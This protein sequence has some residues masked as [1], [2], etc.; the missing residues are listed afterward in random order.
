[1]ADLI[2]GTTQTLIS[3]KS[4]RTRVGGSGF[5]AFYWR[6]SP[7][8]FCRQIAHTA[9]T[10]VGPG[11]TPIH[12]LDEPYAIEII[13]P[14]AQNIGTLT[15]ELYELYNHKVW[16]ALADIAG[17]IDLVNIFI[18]VAA[19]KDP[20]TVVKLIQPPTIRGINPTPYA[21]RFHNCVI[22]NVEDGETIEI[23]TMEITKRLTIAYTHMTRDNA[24]ANDAL[25]MRNGR[26]SSVTV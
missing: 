16:D 15:L 17:S 8:G 6:T 7:I 14:A 9:P 26:Q 5:T 4:A 1:M 20:I 12:P 2:Q 24:D 13:T 11:P 25:A 18:R 19:L 21:E 23:G 10:P 3:G 22:T